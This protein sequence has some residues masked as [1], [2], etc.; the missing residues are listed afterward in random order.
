[1]GSARTFA[2]GFDDP[3]YDE[4][5]WS[6]A[7]A[8]HLGVEHR[9]EILHPDILDLFDRLMFFMDDP[10]GDFSIFPTFLVSC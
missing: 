7:V 10:I 1:M 3:S 9:V 6:S 8:E 4:T 5:P 2:I